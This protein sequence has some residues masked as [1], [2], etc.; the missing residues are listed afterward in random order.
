MTTRP[1][2]KADIGLCQ[3]DSQ[4]TGGIITSL[5]KTSCSRVPKTDFGRPYKVSIRQYSTAFCILSTV[6]VVA[7][8]PSPI[9]IKFMT[10]SIQQH[11]QPIS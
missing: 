1:R 4:T 5:L 9:I 2:F 3:T 6:L 11:R 8:R 7:R 10:S